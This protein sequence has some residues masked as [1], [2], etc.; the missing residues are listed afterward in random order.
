[1]WPFLEVFSTLL[2]REDKLVDPCFYLLAAK[3][4]CVQGGFS[5]SVLFSSGLVSENLL[6]M[7]QPKFNNKRRSFLGVV[8]LAPL[9]AY[10]RTI[11]AASSPVIENDNYGDNQYVVKN[12]WVLTSMDLDS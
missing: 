3:I 1:L 7:K 4:V 11:K 5:S 2:S 6:F 9:L 12:G 10:G 8:V